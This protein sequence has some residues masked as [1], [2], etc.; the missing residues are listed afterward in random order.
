MRIYKLL[1]II[2]TFG[3]TSKYRDVVI[4]KYSDGKVKTIE[5]YI[6]AKRIRRIS[7]FL[8]E[9]KEREENYNDSILNG[10]TTL[11]YETGIVKTKCN[12][13]NGKQAG[14]FEEFDSLGKKVK[15][16]IYSNGKMIKLIYF[17]NGKKSCEIN[18]IEKRIYSYYENG[19]IEAEVPNYD[20]T[21]KYFYKNGK[22]KKLGFFKEGKEN[23]IWNFFD[24]KETL[25][26]N[27]NYKDGVA[28]DSVYYQ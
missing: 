18:E 24:E 9:K 3:C 17:K 21:C 4:E 10:V 22:K 20:D 28:I 12:Y 1:I 8:N 23:G 13:L 6:G 5:Q 27:V 26:K 19:N 2:V 14:S 7:F 25:K 16:T 11:Y 15:E